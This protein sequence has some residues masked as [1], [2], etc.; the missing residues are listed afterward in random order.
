MQHSIKR[1]CETGHHEHV[2]PR[3]E[4]PILKRPSLLFAIHSD[5]TEILRK[6]S[7]QVHGPHRFR[8]LARASPGM[9][10][11]VIEKTIHNQ[12]ALAA[13]SI[14]GARRVRRCDFCGQGF[15]FHFA[16]PWSDLMS[17]NGQIQLEPPSAPDRK[18][19]RLNSSHDQISYAVFC[20]KKKKPNKPQQPQIQ[21]TLPID[22]TTTK[23]PYL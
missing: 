12:N 13:K 20:L 6:G 23:P 8:H 18:S 1:G 15:S 14:W 2:R 22:P 21:T 10:P 5:F 17:G 4:V 9:A 19:T 16:S 7:G 3:K 11:L